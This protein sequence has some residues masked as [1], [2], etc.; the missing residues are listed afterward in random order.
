MYQVCIK[1][2]GLTTL[3]QAKSCIGIGVDWLGINCYPESPRYVKPE[4]ILNIINK[5]PE[6]VKIVG[7]FVNEDVEKVREL[8]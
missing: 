1:V 3:E 6:H 8:L 2:C 7:V 5:L 4:R